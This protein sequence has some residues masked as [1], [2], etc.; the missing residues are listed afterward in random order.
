MARESEKSLAAATVGPIEEGTEAGAK[1]DSETSGAAVEVL[2]R[3][4]QRAAR[5][6]SPLAESSGRLGELE[7]AAKVS[8]Q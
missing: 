2:T 6:E 7:A 8:R 5:V 4:V 1:G 3:G